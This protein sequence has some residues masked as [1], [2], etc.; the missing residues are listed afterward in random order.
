MAFAYPAYPAL[1][2]ASSS[3]ASEASRAERDNPPVTAKCRGRQY[4]LMAMLSFMALAARVA[5]ACLSWPL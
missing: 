3:N 4:R 5:I 1:A 2:R